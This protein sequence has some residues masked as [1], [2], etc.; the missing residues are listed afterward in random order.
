LQVQTIEIK[1]IGHDFKIKMLTKEFQ[2]TCK[3]T[4]LM[5]WESGQFMCSLLAE[6]LSIIAGKRVLELGCGSAGICSMDAPSFS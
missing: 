3:L 4:G 1:A 6:N 5:L 2:H